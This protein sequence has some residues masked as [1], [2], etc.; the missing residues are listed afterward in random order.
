MEIPSSIL[1]KFS[2]SRDSLLDSVRLQIDDALLMQIASAN[3]GELSAEMMDRL[4]AI[5]DAGCI[6]TPTI[7][8]FGELLTL[9]LHSFIARNEASQESRRKHQIRIFAC[10]LLFR[11]I[12]D[13]ANEHV[14]PSPDTI[15]PV[16]LES[17]GAL[18]EKFG[19][20]AARFLTWLIPC[21]T[22]WPDPVFLP[23][24][25]LLLAVR[26]RSSRFSEPELGN[27]ADWVL[28]EDS[29]W[30]QSVGP[31]LALDLRRDRFSVSRGL[32]LALADE[33]S[34]AAAKISDGDVRTQLK[35]CALLVQP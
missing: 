8:Q 27:L 29:R 19:V 7:W 32:W 16:L 4:R 26:L 31:T 21:N 12:L 1:S 23:F 2:P 14:G 17:A 22:S 3:Y 11:V 20:E 13:P 34:Q 10:V 35:L 30:R 24:A 33:L 25:L 28:A 9:T 18:G 6:S 15:L 5:R